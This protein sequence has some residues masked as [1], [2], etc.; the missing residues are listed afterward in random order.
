M[1]PDHISIRI[2]DYRADIYLSALRAMPPSNFRKMLRLMR[3]PRNTCQSDIPVLG[4][5]LRRATSA[6]EDR[7]QEAEADYISGYKEVPNKRSRKKKVRDILRRN[8]E[9]REAL[10]VAR[11]RYEALQRRLDIFTKI[12]TQKG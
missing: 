10:Q 5:Y 1:P 12:S 11:H 7:Y 4:E 9:L 2:D 8:R 6:A 3:D